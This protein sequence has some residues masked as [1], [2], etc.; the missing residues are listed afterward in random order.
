M[1]HPDYGVPFGQDRPVLLWL[2]TVA[3]RQRN[4]VVRF[5]SAAEI[6]VEWGMQTNGSH[7]RRLQEA[8]RRVFAS[9]IFFGTKEELREARVWDCSRG[10]FLDHMQLWF[11][12]DGSMAGQGGKYRHSLPGIL[13]RTQ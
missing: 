9:T 4:P 8:F 5:G 3:V 1:G 11:G 13:D 7:Y 12:K 2:A 10:H 6:L